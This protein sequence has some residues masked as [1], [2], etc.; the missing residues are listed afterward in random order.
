MSPEG[1]H[2]YEMP[3]ARPLNDP[4]VEAFLSGRGTPS[5]E[6]EPLMAFGEDVRLVVSAPPPVPS[7]ALAVLMTEGLSSPPARVPQAA[8]MNERRK[9]MAFPPQL[10]SGIGAKLAAL[11]LAAKISLGVGVATAGIAAAGTTGVLGDDVQNGL[12]EAVESTTGIDLGGSLDQVIPDDQL[13]DVSI[14]ETPE[15]SVPELPEVPDVTDDLDDTT[16]GEPAE[17]KANHGACV[18]A[19][20]HQK[21]ADGSSHG[22]AVSQI[23]RSDCGKDGQTGNSTTS[24]T[25]IPDDDELSEQQSNRGP[26]N[27]NANGHSNRGPGSSS[28]NRGPGGGN[29]K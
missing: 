5:E 20:A 8:P 23:A 1:V 7:P 2:D 14:P 21:P 3:N 13:P 19:A 22:K 4:A 26:G 17:R 18:S 11:G 10:G 12:A 6:L 28:A 29:N 9:T 24:T 15:V 25:S 27:G 16:D